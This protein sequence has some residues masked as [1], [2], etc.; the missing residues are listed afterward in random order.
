VGRRD[1]QRQDT[2][3]RLL[4]AARVQFAERGFEA[5]QL[6]DIAAAAGVAT[7]TVFVHFSDKRDLLHAALFDSLEAAL[8]QALGGGPEGLEPWLS[9][10]AGAFFDHYAAH[11]TLSRVLLRESL[12]SEPPWSERFTGQLA[13]VHAAVV[14]R[15][16]AARARGEVT[17]DAA[18]FAVAFVSFYTFA[19]LAWVQGAHPAP[20]E[21]VARLVA[22]HLAGARP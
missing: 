1:Q 18:L 11:P 14:V 16:E 21:L 3:Q 17:G 2:R 4:E 22:A 7:G 8:E 6:R 12:I 9:H 15:F 19:L 5:T 10:L 13:R 20:R